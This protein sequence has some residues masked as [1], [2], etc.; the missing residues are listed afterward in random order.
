[1]LA[2]TGPPSSSLFP[3]LP[4]FPAELMG[5][6]SQPRP[7]QLQKSKM[8]AQI[9]RADLHLQ[10]HAGANPSLHLL[11][12]GLTPLTSPDCHVC[13]HGNILQPWKCVPIAKAP[14]AACGPRFSPVSCHWPLPL[15]STA[16]RYP[17]PPLPSQHWH[18]LDP[19]PVTGPH[20]NVH[21]RGETV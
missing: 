9:P 14:V 17:A 16:T 10:L 19:N 1:M 15:S 8:P 6:S 13:T 18:T 3:I 12:T 21:T 20:G 5:T 2:D 7:L 4:L 11:S